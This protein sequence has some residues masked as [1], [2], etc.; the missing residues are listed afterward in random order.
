VFS[1]RPVV[2]WREG[3]EQDSTHRLHL[4]ITIRQPVQDAYRCSRLSQ[5]SFLWDEAMFPGHIWMTASGT[6]S[7]KG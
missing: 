7:S 3:E 5:I 4:L 6:L 2:G 1:D